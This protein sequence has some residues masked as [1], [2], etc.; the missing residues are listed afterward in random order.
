MG[1]VFYPHQLVGGA[2]CGNFGRVYTWVQITLVADVKF[3]IKVPTMAAC[4][5]NFPSTENQ[6][7]FQSDVLHSS[8]LSLGPRRKSPSCVKLSSLI[9]ASYLKYHEYAVVFSCFLTVI[10]VTLK[11]CDQDARWSKSRMFP[12]VSQRNGIFKRLVL[13]IFNGTLTFK[14]IT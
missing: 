12:E 9:I 11:T 2:T 6:F 5:A 10:K 4:P 1:V 14:N 8:D 3:L 7:F 13:H